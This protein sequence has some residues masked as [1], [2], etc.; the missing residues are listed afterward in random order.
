MARLDR[1]VPASLCPVLVV[2]L[3]AL[4]EV[5]RERLTPS[6]ATAIASL[7]GAIGRVYAI[8]SLEDRLAAL[9]AAQERLR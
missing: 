4:D 5:H 7:A 2:L 6:Q 8:A 1:L 3:T 9:E